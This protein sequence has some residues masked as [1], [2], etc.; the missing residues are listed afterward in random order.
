MYFMIKKNNINSNNFIMVLFWSLFA[1]FSAYEGYLPSGIGGLTRYIIIFWV[2]YMALILKRKMLKVTYPQFAML[3]WLFY[4]LCSIGWS[5]NVGQAKVYI[6]TISLMVVVYIMTQYFSYTGDMIKTILVIYKYVSCSLALLSV[7]FYTYIGAGTRRVLYIFDMYMD[8]NNQVA[9]LS[10]GSGLCLLG[11]LSGS[12]I[13]RLIDLS[14]YLVSVYSIFQCGSRSGIVILAIQIIIVMLFWHP[15][16]NNIF[17]EIIKWIII[18]FSGIIAI[19]FLSQYI[20]GDVIDR[21]F[22]RGNLKFTDGTEREERWDVGIKYFLSSPVFGNGW[23]SF[24]C[25][26][27]FLTMLV[28]VGIFGNAFFYYIIIRTFCK[29]INGRDIYVLMILLSGLVPSFF[30]G[31]QNKRFFWS[32]IILASIIVDCK[33]EKNV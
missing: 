3:I 9:I 32:A 16:N 26:N 19:Y 24:E 22:G 17:K 6:F 7:F 4:Y 5:K 10:I 25:H 1:F 11:I 21:L 30:I 20:S 13:K 18:V 29:A 23:G 15:Q 27:T 31:A 2:I 33:K 14:G 8:P 28:D 12:Y